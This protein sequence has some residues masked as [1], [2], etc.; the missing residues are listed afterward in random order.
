MRTTSLFV[1]LLPLLAVA[2]C[3][4][5]PP[6]PPATTAAATASPTPPPIP[7]ARLPAGLP[8]LI[9]RELFFD[10]PE[11]SGGQISPDGKFISFRRPYKGVLNIWVKRREEPFQAARPLT[12]DTKRPVT[13]Y[14]W[15][16]DS[17]RVL[18]AQDK[19]GDENYRI[20]AVDPAAAP[21]AA[22]GVPP[23]RDLTPYPGVRAEILDVPEST[24]GTLIVGLNDRDPQLHDVY[25]VEI[26]TGKRE[27]VFKNEQNLLGYSFDLKGKLRLG[28]RMT[29]SGGTEILRVDGNGKK[30]VSIYTCT[31]DEACAPVRF[32]KDGKRVYL[33]TN[34]GDPDLTRL[35]L[36]D[37]RTKRE[38]VVE[39]DPEKQVDFGGA[40]F[41]DAT[42]E[43]VA[44]Y[45]EGDRLRTY[46]RT[47]PFKHDYETVRKALPDGDLSFQSSTEDDRL[48]IVSVNS[49]TDPGAV[50]LYDRATG[51]VEFLY[52]P[53]PKLPT[54]HLATMKPVRYTARDGVSIP[55][56][57]TI[58]KGV[59]PRGLPTVL[60]PHGGPWA[61]DNWGYNGWSQFLA[62]RGYAVLQPNF[63]GSTGYGKKFLNLG[64]KQWGTGT[65]QH[66]LTDAAK[67]LADQGI[68]DPKRI[69]ISGGSYGGYATLAGV[70]FTPD[71]YAAAVDLVGPS[72]II[73]LLKSIPPYWAPAKKM[74]AVRV[75]DMDD[76]A[77]LE[78]L[79]AQSPLYAAKNIKTPLLV[80][81]GANDPRVKQAESDQIVAAVRDS[82][83]PVEYIVAPDE[84]H[85]F[86]GKENRLA[87]FTAMETF[88]ARYLGGRYQDSVPPPI[89]QRLASLTVDVKKVVARPA[90]R[91]EP[92]VAKQPTFSGD[93]LRAATFKYAYTGQ[94]MG[95][96]ME[97]SSTVTVAAG[98]RADR[99]IWT[100]NEQSKT[101]LGE[102]S[103]TTVLDKKTLL[104]IGRS[105]RQG[106]ATV[107]LEFTPQEA[108]G[109]MKA[110]PQEMPINAKLDGAVLVDNMSLHLAIGTLPLAPGYKTT[111]RS[112]DLMGAKAELQTLEVKSAE[113]VTT[114][115]GKFSAL[116]VQVTPAESGGSLL[117]WVEKAP[118][119]RVLKWNAT[120]PPQR[121]GGKV[122]AE[123]V[124]G[125]K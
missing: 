73:T 56:Y 18:Y 85:G 11:I 33:E 77:E 117:L 66:D 79:K 112:F 83:H 80:I 27:L 8:P 102:G 19:G 15:S 124:D 46:P 110:G 14:F 21:E 30:L 16:E 4:E 17:K 53:R 87:M 69:A 104:P 115:A 103:D 1:C 114:P 24:P 20:Y 119:H 6:P 97:G 64:N 84:G 93:A 88:F 31:A 81:Q 12:A 95:K 78:R 42:E 61:R 105:V 125:G 98:T 29:P 9:D 54:Q 99:P 43:L 59:E 92:A 44:T 122:S 28:A 50:Y 107:E 108:R 118:P 26:A 62:N 76:P 111:L 52:R 96:K 120:L 2:G 71:L 86:A 45:Y 109:K 32:H 7:A 35:V 38:E 68:A 70:A 123:L 36:F 121:G 39:S 89:A 57:L 37:P 34:K 40:R 101:S 48:Q 65:M 55:A 63:R 94:M 75:G 67:W 51:K 10:D 106:P 47:A 41:S 5:A 90:V 25:K 82:G 58:P 3:A 49:D 113:E 13:N 60:F 74:F 91:E 100:I 23:A 22:T 72:S 116:L